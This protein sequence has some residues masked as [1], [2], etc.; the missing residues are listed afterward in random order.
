MS[1]TLFSKIVCPVDFSDYSLRALRYAT[2]LA[3]RFGGRVTIVHVANPL[4]LQAAAT[5]YDVAAMNT[6]TQTELRALAEAVTSE[7]SAVTPEIRTVARVGDP[8][9]EIISCG[10]DEQADLIVMG[11]HGR[12]G[13]RRMFFG[14]V[15]EQ[16]LRRSS[17][18][19]LAV[20]PLG[21]DHD[22]GLAEAPMVSGEHRAP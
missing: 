12:S 15:T 8:A 20:P 22:D 13:Y 9:T 5:A 21:L 14:S 17:V 4:L 10:R 2:V 3:G 1:S 18:P 16:V 19:V 7:A 11:T 6:D